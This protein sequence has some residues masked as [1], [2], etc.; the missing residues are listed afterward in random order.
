MKII[1]YIRIFLVFYA[2]SGTIHSFSQI[3]HSSIQFQEINK[4]NDY[5]SRSCI[6]PANFEV[7]T[8]TVEYDQY[9]LNFS[10]E[11]DE[12]EPGW[13][14]WDD[15]VN[16]GGVGT[17]PD[18]WLCAAARWDQ[19]QLS[20]Y[21]GFTFV[22]IKAF[23]NDDKYDSLTFFIY[24]GNSNDD[25]IYTSR[26]DTVIGH[27]WIEDV[28]DTVIAINGVA[29]YW[30]GY[31]IWLPYPAN[32]PLGYDNG[33]AITGY[34]D[35]ISTNNGISWDNLS[36]FGIDNNW[37][38]Q[39]YVE[40]TS[41]NQ[42][43][44]AKEIVVRN[45]KF[46]GYNLYQRINGGDFE[47]LE[48]IPWVIGDTTHSVP[49]EANAEVY[50]YQLTA[51]W[52]IG[53]DTCESAPAISKE[54]PE[55]DFVCVLLVGNEENRIERSGLVRCFPNPF[56]NS[57]TIEYTL[58]L[59]Q[60]VQISIFNNLG[61]QVGF[62]QEKQSSGKQQVVWDAKGLP[63]GMYYFMVQIGREILRG[64]MLIVR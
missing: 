15:G 10:W 4:S 20:E 62:I 8:D 7:E 1:N 34:G 13:I 27:A 59:T 40:D 25:Q 24:E 33:P 57:T 14:H 44:I 60:L 2:L 35:K 19:G 16:V 31:K 41:G 29:E 5:H 45:V 55:E 18:C 9:Q 52:T 3:N 63:S 6:A 38:I 12:P 54:N 53:A 48:F 46:I 37:N 64:K 43:N 23:L 61:E 30:V 56:S 36:D 28:P 11:M 22:K 21:H 49:F 47:L 42:K 50:C 58:S 39:F 32:F 26:H 51:I 17:C